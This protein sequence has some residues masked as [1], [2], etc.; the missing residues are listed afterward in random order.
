MSNAI[1]SSVLPAAMPLSECTGDSSACGPTKSVY[2]GAGAQDPDGLDR[3]QRPNAKTF[4]G[5][6]PENVPVPQKTIPS[7]MVGPALQAP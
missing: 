3:P 1:A 2:D 6:A 4:F 5:P 7:A